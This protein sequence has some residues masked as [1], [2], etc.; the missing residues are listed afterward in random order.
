MGEINTDIDSAANWR[1]TRDIAKLELQVCKLSTRL[2]YLRYIE[3][4]RDEARAE[5]D[6]LK[7]ELVRVEELGRQCSENEE[8][9]CAQVTLLGEALKA[10]EHGSCD[11][12][13][14]HRHCPVCGEER[15]GSHR[16]DCVVGLALAAT[17]PKP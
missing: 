4:E 1:A 3:K 12:C 17:E 16:P 8:Q 15:H 14:A 10:T 9:A 5:V 2:G 7:A 13:G 11:G 6:R